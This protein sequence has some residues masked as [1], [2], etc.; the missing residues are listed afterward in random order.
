MLGTRRKGASAVEPWRAL[1]TQQGT[2]REPGQKMWQALGDSREQRTARETGMGMRQAS[3]RPAH[4]F[5]HTVLTE[6][7]TQDFQFQ[8]PEQVASTLCSPAD[9]RRGRHPNSWNSQDR[10]TAVDLMRH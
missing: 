4:Q 1:A 5:H 10:Q 6:W 7:D 9:R 8:E 2:K 3:S